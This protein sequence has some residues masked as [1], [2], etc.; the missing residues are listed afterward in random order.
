MKDFLTRI[1]GWFTDQRRQALQAMVAS[2]TSLLV[3]LGAVTDVQSSA[4]LDL[5]ASGLLA[6]QGA[7]GL[8]L[9]RPGDRFT[10][11]NT[12]GRGV[13]YSLGGAIGV[14]GFTFSLWSEA[15]SSLMLQVATVLASILVGALQMVNAGTL[16]PAPAPV[17]D[18]VVPIERLRTGKPLLRSGGLRVAIF[19]PYGDVPSL[20]DVRA[21][22]APTPVTIE[23]FRL[24][25]AMRP[26]TFD[27]VLVTVP[28]TRGLIETFEPNVATSIYEGPRVQSAAST[29]G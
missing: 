29:N 17:A 9:L 16:S 7:L 1:A 13:I 15:T 21:R 12:T 18:L 22:F 14:V 23:V 8:F 2:A 3:I 6:L 27:V 11:L 4:L 24:A 10:W 25:T 28:L 20:D 5:S 26:L 19:A